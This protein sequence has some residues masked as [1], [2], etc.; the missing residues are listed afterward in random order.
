MVV[1]VFGA[2]YGLAVAK[3]IYKVSQSHHENESSSYQS[4][5]FSMIGQ[6]AYSSYTIIYLILC[7][8]VYV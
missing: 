3:T 2:Y 7:N 1:H 8:T 5:I 4:D 6:F